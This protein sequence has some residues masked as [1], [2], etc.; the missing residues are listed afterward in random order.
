MDGLKGEA[1][2]QLTP[3]ELEVARLVH[4][5]LRNREIA[6]RLACAPGTV[7]VHMSRILSKTGL[8]NRTQIAVWQQYWQ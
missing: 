5:G 1:K 4:E 3:R 7:K 2:E 6:Q 8:T